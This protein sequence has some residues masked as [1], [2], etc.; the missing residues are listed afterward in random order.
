MNKRS[1]LAI[2]FEWMHVDSTPFLWIKW[3][4]VKCEIIILESWQDTKFWFG[5]NYNYRNYY[6]NENHQSDS[7]KF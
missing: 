6:N 1:D 7:S 5:S 3:D 4:A 2:V